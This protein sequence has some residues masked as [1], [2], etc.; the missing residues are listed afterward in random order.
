MQEFT[1]L[2]VAFFGSSSRWVCVWLCVVEMYSIYDFGYI[3]TNIT[4]LKQRR[5]LSYRHVWFSQQLCLSNQHI[6]PIIGFPFPDNQTPLSQSSLNFSK[7]Q[8]CK[9]MTNKGTYHIYLYLSRWKYF[10]RNDKL[11]ERER[12]EWWSAVEE[13][14]N[15]TMGK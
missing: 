11:R 2:Q 5:Q 6:P 3:Y 12:E 9:R 13:I 4:Y 10:W 14:Q 1:Q 8:L 15:V 7:F